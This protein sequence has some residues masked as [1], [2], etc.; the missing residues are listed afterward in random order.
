[1][2]NRLCYF[3]KKEIFIG[4]CYDCKT[5]INCNRVISSYDYN[6]N[7]LLFAHIFTNDLWI[8]FNFINYSGLINRKKMS[9][10]NT[11][12]I[13]KSKGD[14]IFTISLSCYDGNLAEFVSRIN[15]LIA[16]S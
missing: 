7:E 1:M 6:H 12:D 13:M 11:I 8:R 2:S 16:F 9:Y 14:S 5:L 4:E 3:C 10:E 15:T